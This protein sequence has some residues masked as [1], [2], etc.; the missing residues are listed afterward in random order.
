MK[1]RF[2]RILLG[3]ALVLAP[4]A[5][6][7]ATVEETLRQPAPPRLVAESRAGDAMAAAHVRPAEPDRAAP[8]AAPRAVPAN[9]GAPGGDVAVL[10]ALLRSGNV[11]RLRGTFNGS[12]GATLGLYAPEQ[13]YFAALTQ[14]NKL[15]RVFRSLDNRRAE[16]VYRD[17]V[18][19]SADLGAA[20]L[21]RVR[22]ETEKAYSDR[23]IA[24]QKARA[25]QLQADLDVARAQQ[26]RA[27]SY[28]LEQQEA[29]K[30]LRAEQ[31]TANARLSAL[32]QHLQELQ[33][34]A[35]SDASSSEQ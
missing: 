23:M 29:I 9:P 32:R 25:G 31:V 19:S 34:R 26:L 5:S 20:E 28:Q 24:E 4:F 12:Y 7:Y 11:I 3:G 14:D 35:E 2:H 15:W 22:L 17:F 21:R 16:S 27:A 6:M 18:R 10:D 33:M 1:R 13:L 8:A 30:A